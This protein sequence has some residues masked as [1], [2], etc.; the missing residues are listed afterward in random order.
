[1]GTVVVPT[2]RTPLHPV[3][4]VMLLIKWCFSHGCEISQS[5]QA[6][7]APSIT[8]G[9]ANPWDRPR[10]QAHTWGDNNH[11]MG[12]TG[13]LGK[14]PAETTFFWQHNSCVLNKTF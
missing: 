3:F 12:K 13:A 14:K 5:K 1:M 2:S 7:P 8:A 11:Q 10:G 4:L 6:Q 9:A